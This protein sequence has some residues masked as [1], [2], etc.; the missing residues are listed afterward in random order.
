MGYRMTDN[1]KAMVGTGY[2]GHDF[3]LLNDR[4]IVDIW[5]KLCSQQSARAVFDLHDPRDGPQV[6]KLYGDRDRWKLVD[7][8]ENAFG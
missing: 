1:P 7:T 5:V 2:E 6:A 3:A 8:Y 4:W